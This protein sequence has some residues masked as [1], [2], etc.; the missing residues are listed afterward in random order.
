[1]N[2]IWNILEISKSTNWSSDSPDEGRLCSSSRASTGEAMATWLPASSSHSNHHHNHKPPD[3]HSSHLARDMFN[4]LLKAPSRPHTPVSLSAK[5][6]Q[7]NGGTSTTS[8]PDHEPAVEEDPQVLKFRQ[9]YE[10][11]EAKIASLFSQTGDLISPDRKRKLPESF[12]ATSPGRVPDIIAPESQISTTAPPTSKKRK[13]DDDYDDYDDDDEDEEEVDATI[14]PLKGKSTK[15]QIIADHRHASPVP[16]PIPPSRPSSEAS[17]SEAAKQKEKPEDARK[18]LEEAKRLEIETVKNMSRHFFF[19]LE[20]DRDAMLD[21]QRLDEAEQRAEQEAEGN[22]KGQNGNAAA[23]QQGSLSNANLGASSLTLKNL[24]A[25]I[26]I[27]RSEVQASESELRALMSEVRKNRSKWASEEKVGQEE[28]Y[29][30]AE[31]VLNELKAQTEHSGPFLQPVKKKDAPDYH[32]IIKLPMD[33]GT[34]TKKLKQLTYKSKQDF[35]DELH[36]IWTNCLKYNSAPEHPMRKH[37]LFMRKETDK[38]VPLIPEIVIKDR[39]EIEAEERKQ[40]IANGEFEGDAEDSDDDQ[41]IM[42]SRGRTAPGKKTTTKAPTASSRKS[43]TAGAETPAPESKPNLSQIN[44]VTNGTRADSETG[45]GSEGHSTPPPGILTPTGIERCAGSVID[46][47][48]EIP[49]SEVPGLPFAVTPPEVEDDDFRLWKQKTKKERAMIAAA[50]HKLFRGDKL[51]ADEEALLRSKASMRRWQ[52][53]QSDTL[54]P[55]LLDAEDGKEQ[56]QRGP[57]FAE[58]LEPEEESMLPDYYDPLAAVPDLNPRLRWETDAE[59]QVIDQNEEFLRLYPSGSFTAPPS[60]LSQQVSDN[61]R[62]I[63]E[64]RKIVSKIG[65]VKQM[66]LQTQMY[67]NQFTKYEPAPFYEAD[68]KD[69]VMTDEGPLMAPWVSKAALTRSIGEI[70]FH[71]GFEEFQPSAIDVVADLAGTFFQTLCGNLSRYLTEEKVS[72]P[73]GQPVPGQKMSDLQTEL[74]PAVSN[75]EAVLH[76]L[77]ESGLSLNDMDFYANDEMDRTSTRL[78][79]MYDRMRSHY[80][81]LLKPAMTDDTAQGSGGFET[82]EQY[83]GGDFADELGEDF[84]GFKALGL[85]KEFGLINHSIPLHLLHNRLSSQARQQTD[86]TD[87]TEKL[88]SPPPPYPR[89]NVENVEGEIGLVKEYFK[90]RLKENGDRP[91]PEDQDLPVKQRKGHGRARVPATGK[92]GDGKVGSSPQKKA[93]APN[94]KTENKP[95]GRITLTNGVK[96]DKKKSNASA[97]N[98]DISMM[99]ADGADDTGPPTPSQNHDDDRNDSPEKASQQKTPSKPLKQRPTDIR[100]NS[101]AQSMDRSESTQGGPV[102]NGDYTND[103]DNDNDDNNNND[104]SSFVNGM[105]SPPPSNGSEPGTENAKKSHKEKVKG[106]RKGEKEDDDGMISPESL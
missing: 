105:D 26:D 101:E 88:F 92:I 39:A 70:F 21:Q 63:Q 3:D 58:G 49:D 82:G 33:L 40:R 91:L 1:M 36:L 84:F 51:N 60:K 35:V 71:A 89:V 30:A 83:V 23:M 18:K 4:G 77:H 32:A 55:S 12:D 53:L 46:A 27:Y 64:T 95:V 31:K 17:K 6:R 99:D 104:F 20:N 22:A 34:M 65:V 90:K 86:T 80:A 97:A 57:T 47:A 102:T 81:D 75:E 76:A 37:A 25:R 38:L 61:M 103:N 2:T 78:Q 24:I 28:L 5:L 54:L 19:T 62:Q 42:A 106:K 13:L 67:Q 56:A 7:L 10:E 68:V 59:G 43:T 14:S 87:P 74:R 50:R 85:D 44:S 98:G 45:M 48:S 94:A 72:V 69:V 29:E 9:L 79:T 100:K 96:D 15:V 52:R 73:V 66:Q 93:P 41:P 11:S 16:R 8:A